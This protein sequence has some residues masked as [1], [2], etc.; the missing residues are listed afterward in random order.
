MRIK[1]LAGNMYKSL[2]AAI[3]GTGAAIMVTTTG[4]QSI[5][6]PDQMASSA[7]D[8]QHEQ[9]IDY[10]TELYRQNEYSTFTEPERSAYKILNDIMS[11]T[12]LWTDDYNLINY[13]YGFYVS[14]YD[15]FYNVNK[16]Y[17]DLTAWTWTDGS[18]KLCLTE[19]KAGV[20]AKR[21]EAV[22]A[23]LDN[24]VLY[25]DSSPYDVIRKTAA[26]LNAK[27]DYD[28][29]YKDASLPD[30]IAAGKGVCTH[31]SDIFCILLNV[32]GIPARVQAGSVDASGYGHQ[33]VIAYISG[34]PVLLDP[35]DTDDPTPYKNWTY[36]PAVCSWLSK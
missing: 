18:H 30:A 3:I 25:T 6:T 36:Q 28:I 24:F 5:E 13:V 33:W 9:I 15:S 19:G 34:S 17:G 23:V 8:S 11:G 10:Y 31:Y 7:Y 20:L 32:Q 16:Q 35:T 2:I 27:M 22:E 26:Q 14:G 21:R 29:T 1:A 4:V 12:P